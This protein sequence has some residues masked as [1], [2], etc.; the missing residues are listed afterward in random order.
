MINIKNGQICFENKVFLDNI[1][2]TL[3][4]NKFT[5]MLGP[6]GSG[7]TSIL[8]IIGGVTKLSKGLF[9][10]SFSKTILIPQNTSYP[11]DLTLFEYLSSIYYDSNWKWSISKKEENEIYFILN[12]LNIADK[13][14]LFMNQLSSG[15]L[16]IA[17]TGLCLLSKA[18][19]IILDE[20]GSNLDIINQIMLLDILKQLTSQNITIL[21]VMHDLNLAA[22]YGDYFISVSRKGKVFSGLQKE[23]FSSENLTDVYNYNINVVEVNN[24]ILAHPKI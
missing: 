3:P 9:S 17:N 5:L 11:Q 1:N 21:G 16:Q 23:I 22:K 6:N 14:D 13:K 20:P 7:K 18:D 19:F 10:N 4:K 15:E 24:E 2:I 12:K 8:N